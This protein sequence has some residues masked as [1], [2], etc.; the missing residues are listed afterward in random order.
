MQIKTLDNIN[1]VQ[2]SQ[3]MAIWLAGNLQAHDFVP[4]AFWQEN[5]GAVR[6]SLPNATITVAVNP[7]GQIVGFIGL[8]KD[9]IA[10]LFVAAKYQNQGIGHQLLAF[11]KHQQTVLVLDAFE[12][13]TGAVRFYQRNGF[14]IAE[15]RVEGDT[16]QTEYQMV[17][18]R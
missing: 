2:M 9:Y 8:Q 10:G 6:K 15:R 13:N 16:H 17:W 7:D 12:Q 18:H 1:N 11:V 14:V 4:A 3:L 5:A